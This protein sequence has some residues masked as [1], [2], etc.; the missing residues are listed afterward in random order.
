MPHLPLKDT[1]AGYVPPAPALPC[2]LCKG[3]GLKDGIPKPT[4]GI[5]ATPLMQREPRLMPGLLWLRETG[6]KPMILMNFEL[7]P[8]PLI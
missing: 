3:T 5:L 4:S 8:L 6:T 7:E 2:V 1:V